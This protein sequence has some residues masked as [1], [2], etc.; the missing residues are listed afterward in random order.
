[1]IVSNTPTIRTQHYTYN[2][3]IIT[4]IITYKHDILKTC[5]VRYEKQFLFFLRQ[6]KTQFV[7]KCNFIVANNGIA[8]N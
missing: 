4:G 3:K 2:F 7:L 8:S 1:M 6:F 5:I